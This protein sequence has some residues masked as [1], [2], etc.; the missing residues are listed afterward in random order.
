MKN[1]MK[2]AWEIYKTLTG[3]HLEKLSAALK[4]AWS[5]FKASSAK[6]ELVLKDWL[7]QKIARE[8]GA[9][10]M[11]NGHVDAVF[12]ETEKAYK[13]VMGAVNHT[14]YTWIPKSQCEWV[15]SES[16]T[17]VVNSFE[18]AR[19]HVDYLRNCYC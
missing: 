1:I 4:K 13:I 19:E 11:W 8:N 16:E 10:R 5:E 17:K 14:V 3:K 6:K 12:Q 2:R 7:F 15:D 9:P 18:E